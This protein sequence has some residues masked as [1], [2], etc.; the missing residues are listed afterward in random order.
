MKNIFILLVLPLLF[1]SCA[2][3]FNGKNQRVTLVKKAEQT[4]LINNAAPVIK[5]GK[6][7]L[8]RSNSPVQI[9]VK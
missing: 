7:L 8:P 2:T 9:T 1:S 4:I 3:I 6:Y 5:K